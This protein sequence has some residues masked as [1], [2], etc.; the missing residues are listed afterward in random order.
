[1]TP[2]HE[3]ATFDMTVSLEENVYMLSGDGRVQF[4]CDARLQALLLV[5]KDSDMHQVDICFFFL[6]ET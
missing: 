5:R 2:E 6:L 1:M 4:G 3:L